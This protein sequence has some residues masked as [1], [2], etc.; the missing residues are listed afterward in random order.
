MVQRPLGNDK[1]KK[2]WLEGN[3]AKN[4][5]GI[6]G[7]VR[8]LWEEEYK[9]KYGHNSAPVVDLNPYKR[10]ESSQPKNPDD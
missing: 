7:L 6:K 1:V 8:E 5:I 4:K 9:G 3:P 10:K 2:V